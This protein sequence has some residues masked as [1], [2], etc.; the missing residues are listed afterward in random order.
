MK[1]SLLTGDISPSIRMILLKYLKEGIELSNRKIIIFMGVACLVYLLLAE[2]VFASPAREAVLSRQVVTN[3]GSI[4]GLVKEDGIYVY[5]GIPYAK[6]PVGDLRFAPPQDAEPWAGVFDCTEYGPIAVQYAN[7]SV[8]TKNHEQSEDCLTLNIWTP[9]S[10]D[11]DDKLPVYVFIHGG[12]F[13][14]GSGNEIRYDGT[15]FAKNGVVMVTI[16]YR[17]STL[18]FFSSEE[19][20]NQYRTTGNWGLL[21]Q[22]KALEWVRDN[23]ANFGGDP[24][25]VTIG[26]ESAGSVSVSALIASP[27]AKGLFRSAIME[28]GSI[29]GIPSLTA[30]RGNL[31]KSIETSRLFISIFG[32][33]DNEEGLEQLRQ[34]DADMLNYLS[35]FVLDQSAALQAFFYT[36]LFDGTVLPKDPVAALR[37]GNFNKVNLL[38]GFNHDEGSLFIPA[39][40]DSGSY[41][42]I[43]ARVIGKDWRIYVDHF[44]IDE[45]N[46]ALQRARQVFGYTWFATDTK[47]FGDFLA[48]KGNRVFIYNYNYVASGNPLEDLGA[49]HSSELDFVFNSGVLS[50]DKNKKMAQEMHTRWINFIKNADPNIGAVPPTATQWPQYDPAKPEVIFFDHEVTTGPLPDKENLDFVAELLYGN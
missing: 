37:E 39:I 4:Q 9:C 3:K 8:V 33:S 43:A 38:A 20:Y 30:S 14:F 13:G 28:S 16:N 40:A 26:G 32:Y 10:P 34:V 19:T 18:G 41:K 21:D 6:A 36:P 23:I 50:G 15:S 44:P 31:Q 2:T 45:N 11:A 47:V 42:T 17:L 35:P 12:G 29:L 7:S 49:Y 48:G 1:A 27:L 24:D 22:I 25:K 46:S 5:K